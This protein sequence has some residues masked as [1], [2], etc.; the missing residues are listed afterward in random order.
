[1]KKLYLLTVFLVCCYFSYGQTKG[2]IYKPASTAE[3]RA[4]LDPNK[5]GYTS[6]TTA[7]F[8]SN[9][10]GNGESEIG[11]KAIPILD[12][13]PIQD[14]LRGP[15]CGFTDMV[16]SGV[17]DPVMFYFDGVNFL[18]RFRLNKSSPN[19]KGYS[20]LID[21]GICLSWLKSWKKLIAS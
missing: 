11:Y 14:P 8:K 2:L 17:G 10:R 5:D 7:G 6:K 13:E 1:M 20:V 4:I 9:D 16:D 12:N 19:S 21:L 3:G 18:V 15:G